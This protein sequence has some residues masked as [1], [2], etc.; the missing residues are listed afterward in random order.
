AH[1]APYFIVF[2]GA[3]DTEPPGKPADFRS[4]NAVL[5]AGEASLSWTT[6]ADVG[7]AGTVG[8]FVTVDGKEVPRYLIPLAGKPGERV[9][10]RLRDLGL[11]AGASV[12]VGVPAVDGAG[13]VGT[14]ATAMVKL[15]DHAM[16]TLPGAKGKP[17]TEPAALPRLGGAEVAVVDEL[18]KV[19]PVDGTMIP[20][21]PDGYLAANHLW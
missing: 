6:P 10:M 20:A 1:S 13:N 2:L 18:D 17:F 7:P 14:P 21:Q 4:E 11:K 12:E 19:H 16:P 8:F 5:P 3:K 15:S 9:R